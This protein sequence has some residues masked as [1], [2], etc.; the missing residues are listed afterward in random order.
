MKRLRGLLPFVVLAVVVAGATPAAAQS[1][2][3]AG[4][5]F[6]DGAGKA[7]QLRGINAAVG[8]DGNCV[9]PAYEAKFKNS[10]AYSPTKRSD[11]AAI[12]TWAANTVRITLNEDCWLGINPVK[13]YSDHI[14]PYTGKTARTKGKALGRRYRRQ[15]TQAVNDLRSLGFVVILDL[16][17]SAPGKTLAF[18]QYAVPDL[19]HSPAFWKS[20]ARTF[21]SNSAVMFEIFNEPVFKYEKLTWS[22]LR[23]GCRLPNACADC[24]E[25][26]TTAGGGVIPGCGKRCPTQKHP[27]GTYRTAGT[28]RLVNTIR[29]TGARNPILSPGRRYTNDLGEWLKWKPKDKLGQIGASFHA[30]N[31]LPCQ[32]ACWNST[33]ASVAARVPVA[34]TEFGSDEGGTNPCASDAAWDENYLNWADSK[35]V[36]YMAW[37]WFVPGPFDIPDPNACDLSLLA[38]Y[39]GTPRFGHGAAVRAHYLARAGN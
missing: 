14:K 16:H 23:D 13:R 17:L 7:I 33:I 21:R 20:V 2:K 30:N 1:V 4:N 11:F 22:C 15:V 34:T 36:S 37:W 27:R 25:G 9:L 38:D 10:F 6:V 32:D 3:I 39:G 29:A 24:G 8:S 28:Q 31:G 18:A 35:G 19:D 26:L 5:Q 12:K